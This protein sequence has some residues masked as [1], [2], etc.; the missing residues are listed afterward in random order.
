[1]KFSVF[2]CSQGG[3][4]IENIVFLEGT[5]QR[6]CIDIG[7]THLLL[8]NRWDALEIINLNR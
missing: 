3:Q 1:M 2:W 5:Q 4:V 6:G 7:S 8:I